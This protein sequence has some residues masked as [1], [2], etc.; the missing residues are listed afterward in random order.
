M[1]RPAASAAWSAAVSG[2]LASRATVVRRPALAWGD[3]AK[4]SC[5]GSSSSPS[6]RAPDR[7]A[8]RRP[9][10]TLGRSRW[11]Q[12]R[13]CGGTAATSVSARG[14][15]AGGSSPCAVNCWPSS[16]KAHRHAVSRRP[17]A[18][19]SAPG[20]SLSAARAGMG[21]R[22]TRTDMKVAC[23]AP[24]DLQAPPH[25]GAAASWRTDCTLAPG[26]RA[27]HPQPWSSGRVSL[28]VPAAVRP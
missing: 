24:G 14:H 26:P 4:C 9:A 12:D 5:S 28:V 27:G 13:A 1:F 21:R 10:G 20:A 7:A 15:R 18:A 23:S 2:A 6:S 16:D 19:M 11:A 22:T 17:G 3:S 25:S 8:R